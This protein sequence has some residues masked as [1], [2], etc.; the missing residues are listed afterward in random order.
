MTDNPL[1]PPPDDE[2]ATVEA[3]PVGDRRR[4]RDR[5]RDPATERRPGNA[6]QALAV[7]ALG[8]ALALVLNAPG[9]HKRA[10]NMGDGWQ[11]EV[12][13]AVTGPVERLAGGIRL[14]LPRRAVQAAAG[15]SG[16]DEIDTQIALPDAPTTTPEPDP[17][18]PRKEA[19]SPTRKL[20]FWVAGDSLIVTP[21]ESIV[22][23]AGASPVLEAVGGIDGRIATGLGRPDVFNWFAEMRRELRTSKPDVVILGFGGNDDKAYMTGLPDGVSVGSFGSTAWRREYGRRVG[24]VMDIVA[25]AG[26]HVV[27]IGLAQTDDPAQT[28]RFDVVNSVVAAEARRRP[29]ITTYVDTYTLFASE[30]GGFTQY[31]ADA[32]GVSRKVRADDGV[33]FERAGGDLIARE[34]LRALNRTF[35][36]TSWKRQR[37]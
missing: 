26:G 21:G 2:T 1:P 22:R 12:A 37:P 36:L 35:D 27:W 17:D 6:G 30:T 25:R 15:R 9:A 31:L 16:V 19:F 8:L 29:Q 10:Y 28:R 34:V 23:A 13:L 20:R 11:R 24:G 33:H 14:D 32:T 3:M 7:C 18:P 5:R 4:S